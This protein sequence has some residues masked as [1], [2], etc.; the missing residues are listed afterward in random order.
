MLDGSQPAATAIE[1]KFLKLPKLKKLP[2]GREWTY[3][4]RADCGRGLVKI[5]H[6]V[7]LKWRLTGLQTQCPVQL[8][9]I[10]L[11]ETPA[12]AEFLF[13][14]AL[15]SSR[16]HGE[17]FYPTTDLERIRLALPKGGSIEG[18]ELV[19]ILSRFGISEDRIHQVFVWALTTAKHSDKHR[20][21]P[22][23]RLAERAV[24]TA[25]QSGWRDTAYSWMIFPDAFF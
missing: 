13:H 20:G 14:E 10:G 16:A 1:N 7:N 4:L 19:E 24:K 15:A 21:R 3:F 8:S 5:G 25:K 6:S 22:N 23:L 9:L 2:K 11:V 18:P 17:W 12:G